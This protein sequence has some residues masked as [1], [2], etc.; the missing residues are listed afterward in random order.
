MVKKKITEAEFPTDLKDKTAIDWDNIFAEPA[1][2]QLSTT[3]ANSSID[4]SKPVEVP[5]FKVGSA[6]DTQRATANITPT[7]SMRDMMSRLNVPVDDGEIDEPVDNLPALSNVSPQQLPA[8]ISREIAMSD[9]YAV[10]PTWHTVANLPGNMSKA[11]M[12]LGK[13]VF[14]AFTKTPIK[15]IV[16]IASVGG[17]GPNTTR[18]VRSVAA[19]IVKHGREVDAA[20]ID[21]DASMPG[22]KADVKLYVVGNMRFKLVNDEWGQY[23][24]C[25]PESDSVGAIPELP[26]PT[27]SRPNRSLAR[28]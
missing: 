14:R 9:P 1:G 21:F 13:A 24:Y 5:K 10:N 19:W 7:D 8:L 20:N 23:I 22:Y 6:A 15:D 3:S 4:Q 2:G 12:T 18:E 27:S 25:W 28:R 16:T 11:I 26:A 17:H